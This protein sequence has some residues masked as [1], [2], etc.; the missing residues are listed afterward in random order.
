MH[1][2]KYCPIHLTSWCKTVMPLII[3]AIK[4]IK[5][6]HNLF[7]HQ[8]FKP[9]LMPFPYIFVWYHNTIFLKLYWDDWRIKINTWTA[10]FWHSCFLIATVVA[11]LTHIFAHTNGN[12]HQRNCLNIFFLGGDITKCD[13]KQN[14]WNNDYA[15]LHHICV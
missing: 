8:T 2:Y 9:F 3:Y 7:Q 15:Y 12:W 4:K 5:Q 13:K 6:R 11:P 14:H 1:N 10:T